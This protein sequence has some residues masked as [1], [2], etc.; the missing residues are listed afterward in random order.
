MS[1]H[2]RLSPHFAPD[3][4]YR[5]PRMSKGFRRRQVLRSIIRTAFGIARAIATIVGTIG[6]VA[7]VIT[8]IFMSF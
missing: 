2:I 1:F 3:A 4:P 6:I 8:L 5:A 7:G